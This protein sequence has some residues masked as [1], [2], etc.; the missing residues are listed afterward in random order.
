MEPPIQSDQWPSGSLYVLWA[1]LFVLGI[2]RLVGRDDVPFAI[3]QVS[4]AI[5][6]VLNVLL[7]KSRIARRGIRIAAVLT[8]LGCGI[9][10]IASHRMILGIA[11]LAL[12][13][14]AI[15]AWQYSARRL[16]ANS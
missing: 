7:K 4:A 14:I 6:G 13:P 9:T 1:G 2:M 8:V 5:Y 11:D 10:E 16:R 12:V 15:F 3:L